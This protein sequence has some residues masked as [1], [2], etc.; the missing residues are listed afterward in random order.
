MKNVH[1]LVVEDNQ[2]DILLTKEALNEG[3][4]I[5]KKISIASDGEEAINFLNKV[6]KYATED[7]PDLI[8]LDIN[9]PKKNGI[10]VLQYIKNSEKLRHIPVIILTTSSAEIDV[11]SAYH[12][13][14][15]CFITKPM[16][17]DDFFALMTNLKNFWF[18][19]VRLPAKLELP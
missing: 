15:N 1:I 12:N 18:S 14:A 5:K 3:N 10:E 4:S 8:L 13:L 9:L 11:I 19:V 17:L 16:M 7:S 6:G 2:G